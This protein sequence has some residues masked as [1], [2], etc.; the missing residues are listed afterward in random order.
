MVPLKVIS[1]KAVVWMPSLW[2]QIRPKG[3]GMIKAHQARIGRTTDVTGAETLTAPVAGVTGSG[4]LM[5]VEFKLLEFAEEALGLSNIQ[6]S[7]SVGLTTD[8]RQQR[9][10]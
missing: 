1:W 5:T 7:D 8:S 4:L 6:L 9:S 3:M 10:H 2:P